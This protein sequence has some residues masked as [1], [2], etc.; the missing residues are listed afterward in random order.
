M[1]YTLE[2]NLGKLEKKFLLDSINKNIVSTY[3]NTI[4]EFEKNFSRFVGFKYSAALNSGTS[5]LHLGMLANKVCRNDLVI[6]PSYTFAASVNSILYCGAEPWFHDIDPN[7]MMLDLTQLY[8]SLKKKTIKKGNNYYHYKTKQKVSCILPVMTFGNSMNLKHLKKIKKEFNINILIDAAAGHFSKY[9]D[10]KIGFYGFDCCYS[11]NGNKN[12]TTSSGG[13][14]CTNNKTKNKYVKD[15]S[16]VGRVSKYSYK[17]VGFNYRMSSLQATLGNAQLKNAEKFMKNKNNLFFIYSRYFEK[18][19]FFNQIKSDHF[20]NLA[21][22][23]FAIKTNPK[24]LNKII[25]FLSK[26]KIILSKFWQPIHRQKPYTKFLSE[27]LKFT[28]SE[29]KRILC[30]PSSTFLKKKDAEYI[31]SSLESFVRLIK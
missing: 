26:K 12:I 30:L 19:K 8:L 29:S 3:G 11:F 28:M 9:N 5:A 6:V 15:L 21:G 2:P 25:K 18:N 7:N 23:I 24:I 20:Q 31:L 14:F 10:K 1:I 22:W 4:D 27:D 13:A 16:K 17:Y